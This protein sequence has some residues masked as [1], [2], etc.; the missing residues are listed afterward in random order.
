MKTFSISISSQGE[1]WQDTRTKVNPVLMQPK[2]I[3]RYIGSVDTIATD[4]ITRIRSIRDAKDEVPA[5]FSNEMCKWALESIAYVALNQRLGLLSD[6]PHSDGQRLIDV[7]FH[8]SSFKLFTLINN[9]SLQ[10]VHDFFDLSYKMEIGLPIWKYY[11]TADYKN[12]KN[13][14]NTMTE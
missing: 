14:L 11:K 7:S 12:M 9:S 2:T 6:S 4:F 10:S 3:T 1:M 5:D 8:G 13:C